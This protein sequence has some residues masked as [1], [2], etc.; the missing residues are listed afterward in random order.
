MA[1]CNNNLFAEPLK[2]TD[3]PKLADLPESVERIR[4]IELTTP[5]ELT[6]SNGLPD[7]STEIDCLPTAADQPIEQPIDLPKATDLC[8]IRHVPYTGIDR[9]KT[10]ILIQH[11]IFSNK[12]SWAALGK[13]IADETKRAVYCLDARDHGG[14]SSKETLQL[15]YPSSFVDAN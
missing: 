7:D 5:D 1:D 2:P 11:G 6:K 4:N 13:R 10:P 15:S 9:T 8:Y 14:E 3:L 12:E